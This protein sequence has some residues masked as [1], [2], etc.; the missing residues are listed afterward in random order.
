MWA[1]MRNVKSDRIVKWFYGQ[2]HCDSVRFCA[3]FV[4]WTTF[5]LCARAWIMC[6]KMNLRCGSFDLGD[7]SFFFCGSDFGVALLSV[8]MWLLAVILISWM[9]DRKSVEGNRYY[10]ILDWSLQWS[11]QWFVC[12]W[13]SLTMY[14]P[15]SLL[16]MT[17]SFKGSI[18][19]L[20]LESGVGDG[21]PNVWNWM[22]IGWVCAYLCVWHI[23]LLLMIIHVT[24]SAV[25]SHGKWVGEPS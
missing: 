18:H 5:E 14:K 4:W 13:T 16:Q 3:N 19:Y 12:F 17:I 8:T 20:W 7:Y 1:V 25:N 21:A 6:V 15:N 24:L 2:Y 9:F 22:K 11:R 23:L 10:I